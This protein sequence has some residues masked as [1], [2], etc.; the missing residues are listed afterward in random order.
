MTLSATPSPRARLEQ[1]LDDAHRSGAPAPQSVALCTASP[2]GVPSARTV[3]L[4]ELTSDG[5]VFTTALWTRK[6]ADLQANPR[7]AFLF[8]WP[9]LGRQVHVAGTARVAGRDVAERLFAARPRAHQLQAVVSRQGTEIES[10]EPLRERLA[11]LEA[12]DTAPACPPDWGAVEVIPEAV[13]FWQESS[14]RLHDRLLWRY[15]GE[16]WTETRLAP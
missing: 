4:K 10:L 9:A 7:V 14:D 5:L 1:W 3:S 2:E 11:E 13:E 8:H 6:A 16:R 15:N 12:R